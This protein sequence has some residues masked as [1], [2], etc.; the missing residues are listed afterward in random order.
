MFLCVLDW[1]INQIDITNGG[2]E[3]KLLAQVWNLFFRLAWN[4]WWSRLWC[5][6]SQLRLWWWSWSWWQIEME[7]DW[8]CLFCMPTNRELLARLPPP[9]SRLRPS[10][11]CWLTGSLAAAAQVRSGIQGPLLGGRVWETVA[12]VWESDGSKFLSGWLLCHVMDMDVDYHQDT[13]HSWYL[14]SVSQTFLWRKKFSFVKKFQIKCEIIH[15]D[16][17]LQS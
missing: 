7:K 6:W 4:L 3:I 13:L 15:F 14:Y 2:N 9:D 16:G 1:H 12:Q 17:K 5:S 8:C 11:T 10:V